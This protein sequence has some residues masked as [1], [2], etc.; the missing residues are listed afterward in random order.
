MHYIWVVKSH[1]QDQLDLEL[2]CAF[3]VSNGSINISTYCQPVGL[4]SL[5]RFHPFTRW[6]PS[7]IELSLPGYCRV[8]N[9]GT[10]VRGRTGI[11]HPSAAQL[12]ALSRIVLEC[13][14]AVVSLSLFLL[15]I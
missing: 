9:T 14:S 11:H 7:D 15:Y 4:Y 1:K 2:Q 6:A 3:S 10:R 5:C 12:R 8:S 13:R